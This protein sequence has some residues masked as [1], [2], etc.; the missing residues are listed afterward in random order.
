MDDELRERAHSGALDATTGAATGPSETAVGDGGLPPSVTDLLGPTG[1]LRA[2]TNGRKRQ[3]LV[4]FTAAE[5]AEVEHRAAAFATRFG[6]PVDVAAFCHLAARFAV[7]TGTSGGA[8]ERAGLSGQDALDL[9][10]D[11]AHVRRMLSG[12]GTNLNQLARSANSGQAPTVQGMVAGLERTE[13]AVRRL[14]AWLDLLDPRRVVHRAPA[15]R[16]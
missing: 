14:D 16:R 2:V 12:A 4:R 13:R 6:V 11:L 1:H 10:A 8:R 7:D 9:A 15:R 3:V 5:L